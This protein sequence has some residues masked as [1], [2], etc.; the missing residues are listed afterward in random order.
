M[1]GGGGV[2]SAHRFGVHE[3]HRI[4]CQICGTGLTEPHNWGGGFRGVHPT[5]L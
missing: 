2:W 5:V 3:V 1:G 4:S